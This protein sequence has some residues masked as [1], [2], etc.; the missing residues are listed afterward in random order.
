MIRSERVRPTPRGLAASLLAVAAASALLFVASPA[1]AHGFTSTVYAE[2]TDTTPANPTDVHVELDLE[3]DLLVVSA[4][5][6]EHDDAFFEQGMD[7]FETGR[8]AEALADHADTVLAYV[9]ERFT[10]AEGG[11]ACEPT[12]Q[13]DTTVHERDGVPYALLA[14]DYDCPEASGSEASGS[15]ATEDASEHTVRSALFPDDEG[16]V[17][18]TETILEYDL[19]G[20][21]GSAA[22]DAGHPE[23]STGQAWTDRFAEF[24]VLGAEHL[25]TGI[26]HILFL[27]A[28]IVGSR[29]LRDVVLAAT[30]F[31]IAH[32]IT[33]LLAAVG[34]VAVP[35]AIVEPII[36]LSIAIVAAWYLWR[37]WQQRG[38]ALA[39]PAKPTARLGLDRADWTRLAVVF[40]FGLV[41]GLGFAGA[42]G[43]DEPWSWTLLGSLLVFNVGIEAVQLGIIALVFPAL[44]ALRSKAPRTGMW[45]GAAIAAGVAVMGLVWFVQRVL[46]I[47]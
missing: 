16:Y 17:T 4:A 47:E 19:D 25:L 26:D 14:L 40:G 12:Q 42:L 1:D 13:G 32:S 34:L 43:I 20:Q 2:A 39:Q 21:A 33:F 38:N 10:V 45:A 6:N 46:G 15:E 24:F 30:S 37:L 11:A 22:L 7:L 41:H 28:L 44:L 8:E 31:T 9:T 3:Y 35:A 36:A 29:R 18:G 23:F 5:E 27:L